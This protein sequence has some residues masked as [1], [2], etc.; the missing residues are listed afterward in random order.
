MG[1]SEGR[2]SLSDQ[3]SVLFKGVKHIPVEGRFKEPRGKF[4]GVGAVSY[5]HVKFVAGFLYKLH[6]VHVPHVSPRVVQGITDG[7]Q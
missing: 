2:F 7:R 3:H 1:V 6:G 5:G 4:H